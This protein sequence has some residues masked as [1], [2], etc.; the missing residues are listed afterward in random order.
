MNSSH[1]QDFPNFLDFYIFIKLHTLHS[2]ILLQ[3]NYS[4]ERFNETKSL[5]SETEAAE[6]ANS[7]GFTF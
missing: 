6:K 1:A 5:V 2:A 4:N 7:N 3:K